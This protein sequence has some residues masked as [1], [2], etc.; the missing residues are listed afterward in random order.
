MTTVTT[1]IDLPAAIAD[2]A[3]A[4]AG[5]RQ[6]VDRLQTELHAAIAAGQF[7]VAHRVQTELQAAREE[8][9]VADASVQALR[10]GAERVRRDNETAEA[11]IRAARQRDQA[12]RNLAEARAAEERAQT[13]MNDAVAAMWEA[14]A[15]AQC[16]LRA[17]MAAQQSVTAA[18]HGQIA[19]RGA[20]GEWPAGHPGPTPPKANAVS[21]LTERDPLISALATWSP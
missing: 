2:A 7:D 21:V 15:A 9:A 4:A 16:H 20:L 6:R 19:A 8:Y 3:A 14:V 17:A 18:R 1:A 10:A 13:L 5:P 12:T 11:E